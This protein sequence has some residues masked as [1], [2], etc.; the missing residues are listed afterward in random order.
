MV[1]LKIQ[2][3]ISG[4]VLLVTLVFL[5]LIA[6]I[7]TT[8]M[9]TTILGERMAGNFRSH[10]QA[11][12]A[13]ETALREVE[14]MADT[15]I[16]FS[17]AKLSFPTAPG[18]G[19]GGLCMPDPNAPVWRLNGKNWASSGKATSITLGGNEGDP[20]NSPNPCVLVERLAG[21]GGTS[22][23]ELGNHYIP[24]VDARAPA[25]Y[26]ITILAVGQTGQGVNQ[27]HR[28]RVM[29]QSVYGNNP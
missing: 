28:V 18:C 3:N 19:A 4:M 7:G 27:R 23:N 8:I 1:Y 25:L 20:C 16:F 12:L 14:R 15:G 29:L 2:K 11:F 10:S 22:S 17:D 6:I 5:L 13:A 24:P 9:Q 26:R 21:S